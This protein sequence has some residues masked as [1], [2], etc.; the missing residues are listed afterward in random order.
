MHD[1]ET[2]STNIQVLLRDISTTYSSNFLNGVTYLYNN[3]DSKLI[4]KLTV[5]PNKVQYSVDFSLVN[6]NN[7]DLVEITEVFDSSILTE[8]GWFMWSTVHEYQ[9]THAAY[10]DIIGA[11]S[12][13]RTRNEIQNP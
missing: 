6:M 2:I 1:R 3:V 5:L 13:W 11:F 10:C 7:G 9:L 12:D 4:I 8:E